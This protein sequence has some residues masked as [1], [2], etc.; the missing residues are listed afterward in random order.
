MSIAIA[1]AAL[2]AACGDDERRPAATGPD[3]E[4]SWLELVRGM[5]LQPARGAV[6]V[7]VRGGPPELRVRIEVPASVSGQIAFADGLYGATAYTFADGRWLRVDTADVRTQVAPL[8]S[9]G[10]GA[11]LRL[12][13]RAAE[14]Y[15]ALVPV[16]QRGAWGDAS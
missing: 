3:P 6:A 12:P 9:A 4:E 2:A 10:K 15:R 8:L 1:L 7:G 13:V 11:D 5:N 16:R 14:S